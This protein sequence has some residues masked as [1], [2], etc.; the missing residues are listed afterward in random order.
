MDVLDA[1]RSER[2]YKPAWSASQAR[3]EVDRLS[4]AAFDP[5]CVQALLR[6]WPEIDANYSNPKHP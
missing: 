6:A 5:A 1:L 2:P 3:E 4:G